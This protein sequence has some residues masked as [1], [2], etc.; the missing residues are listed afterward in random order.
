MSVLDKVIDKAQANIPLPVQI[1]GAQLYSKAKR[2][3]FKSAQP[4]VFT[5]SPIPDVADVPLSEI[6]M[7]NPFMYRQ[8]RW[9]SYFKRLR[10]EAPVHFQPNSAFG[11]FWS[12][13]RH[14]D[15]LSAPRKLDVDPLER[16]L[17][18]NPTWRILHPRPW[19]SQAGKQRDK[20]EEF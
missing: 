7:S 4:P 10:D 11:P 5:E 9:Q 20:I 6:D 19:R 18:A 15:I 12:V 8:G 17:G 3:A 2:A 1:R 14:E 13:T 16:E